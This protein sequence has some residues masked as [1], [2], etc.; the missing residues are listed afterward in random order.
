L[1][2]VVVLAGEAEKGSKK[3][4][5]LGPISRLLVGSDNDIL[6]GRKKCWWKSGPGGLHK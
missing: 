2:C 1:V 3:G 6:E 4:P 5:F